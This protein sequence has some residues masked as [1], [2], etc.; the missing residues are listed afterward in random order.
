MEET[1]ASLVDK[2]E[3]LEKQVVDTVSGTTAA[4]SETVDHV[5]EVVQDTVD[6]VKE[7]FQESVASVRETFDLSQQIERHPWLLLGGSVALGYLSGRLLDQSAVA[8]GPRSPSGWSS[9]PP[10]AIQSLRGHGPEGIMAGN[11]AHG[12]STESMREAQKPGFLGSVMSEFSSEINKAK[13]VLVGAGLGLLRDFVAES[14]PDPLKPKVTEVMNSVTAKLGG[15]VVSGPVC[16][17]TNRSETNAFRGSQ[18][19]PSVGAS[20]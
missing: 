20:V 16:N 18:R 5:K 9:P 4:V 11:G 14:V 6:S 13:S 12:G 3:T 1:R 2:I 8:T 10:P 15:E 17:A 7:T 19:E